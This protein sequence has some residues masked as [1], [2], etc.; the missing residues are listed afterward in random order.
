VPPQTLTHRLAHILRAVSIAAREGTKALRCGLP[1]A[2]L[3]FIALDFRATF[4]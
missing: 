2:S 3:L 4:V 1:K